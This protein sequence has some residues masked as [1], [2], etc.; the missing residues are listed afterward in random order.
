MDGNTLV[1]LLNIDDRITQLQ[2]S[3]GRLNVRVRKLRPNEVFEIDT[4]NLALTIRQ[5][6]D[7]RIEVDPAGNATMVAV[8]RGQAEAYGD[9]NAYRLGSGQAYSFGGTD[10]RDVRYARPTWT[11]NSTAG[12]PRATAASSRRVRRA[13]CRPT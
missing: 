2:L 7:Y 12:R 10:L 9:G 8:R 13:T 6:G 3:Q 1:T 11:T 4:P 5:P